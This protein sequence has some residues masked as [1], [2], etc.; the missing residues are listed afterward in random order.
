MAAST[1]RRSTIGTRRRKR[2][3]ADRLHAASAAQDSTAVT[4]RG[5]GSRT[6]ISDAKRDVATAPRR[7]SRG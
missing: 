3:A 4:R 1:T 5:A 6:R 2:R 7:T